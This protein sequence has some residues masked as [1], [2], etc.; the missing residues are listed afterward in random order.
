MYRTS[1]IQNYVPTHLLFELIEEEEGGCALCSGS[2]VSAP[3]VTTLW[4]DPVLS[5]LTKAVD[6]TP[7]PRPSGWGLAVGEVTRFKM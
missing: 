1:H 7:R 5:K 6:P 3:P 2:R 4:Y